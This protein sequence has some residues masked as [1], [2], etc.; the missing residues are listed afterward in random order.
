MNYKNNAIRE[1]QDFTKEFPTYSLGESLYAVIR[2]T[3]AKNISDLLVLSDEEIFS[4]VEKAKIQ[5]KEE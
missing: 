1:I 4:A 2:L 3:G 5:E